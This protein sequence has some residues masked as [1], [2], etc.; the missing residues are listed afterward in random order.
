MGLGRLALFIAAVCFF[1][2][3]VPCRAETVLLV[4]NQS[5]PPKIYREGDRA[6]GILVDIARYV[7]RRLPGVEFEF[8][9]LPWS[10]AYEMAEKGEAGIIGLSMTESRL[11]I[12]D[13]SQVVFYDE[14][15]VVVRRG[16]EF[17]FSSIEDLRGLRVGVGRGG[18][19][20]DDFDRAVQSGL[21]ELIED[22]GDVLRLKM[23]LADRI[24]VALISPGAIAVEQL[25]ANSETL[26]PRRDELVV[27]PTPLKRDPNY[28][29][30]AKS[31]SMQGLIG[32]FNEILQQ[33]YES[34]EIPCIIARHLQE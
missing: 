1:T 22:N 10:R 23:L 27:L 28:L 8:D 31:M 11:E 26:Q 15:V 7:D 17:P 4:G 13:Y 21:F 29:G 30:F 6:M 19:F 14:V 34:G 9:L 2:G 20:G 3:A 12:F 25:V 32:K 24:D 5:K 16:H 33:G 18:T